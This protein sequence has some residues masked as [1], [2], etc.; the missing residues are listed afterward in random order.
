MTARNSSKLTLDAGTQTYLGELDTKLSSLQANLAL[1]SQLV[2]MTI[3][4]TAIR[5]PNSSH[6]K[7]SRG[8]RGQV[9]CIATRR[10]LDF[11]TESV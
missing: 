10:R 11:A 7:F 6:S 2:E 4:S 8:T 5:Q 1:L 3:P 9:V